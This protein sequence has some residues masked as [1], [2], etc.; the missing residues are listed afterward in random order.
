[1][2]FLELWRVSYSAERNHFCYF[3]RGLYGKHSC[4]VILYLD[5]WFR[6]RCHLKKKFTD[7]VQRPITQINEVRLI[8]ECKIIKVKQP[9][10]YARKMIAI[11]GTKLRSYNNKITAL[12][13]TCAAARVFSVFPCS[14]V[15]LYMY[16]LPHVLL[17]TDRAV[18]LK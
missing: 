18:S 16:S 2:S 5:R 6:R 1:M 15:P 10:H 17:K 7:Y 13:P 4:K 11:H 8:Q 3:C 12:E 9:T 14:P